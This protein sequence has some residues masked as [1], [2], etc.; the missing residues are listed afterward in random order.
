MNKNQAYF[1]GTPR[2]DRIFRNVSAPVGFAA[3]TAFFRQAVP[4]L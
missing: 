3:D 4:Y 1:C 2:P